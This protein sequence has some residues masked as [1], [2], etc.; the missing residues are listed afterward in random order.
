MVGGGGRWRLGNLGKVVG[1]VE[2]VVQEFGV[3]GGVQ[4]FEKRGRR[5]ALVARRAHLVYLYRKSNVVVSMD[6]LLSSGAYYALL[7]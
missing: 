4:D 1:D 6:A 3:L 5:V 7:R 2:V